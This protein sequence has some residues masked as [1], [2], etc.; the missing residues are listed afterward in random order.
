MAYEEDF[1]IPAEVAY[2]FAWMLF[3]A[4]LGIAHLYAVANN[5]FFVEGRG[6]TYPIAREYCAICPVVVDCLIEGL[7]SEVG[8]R[9]GCSPVERVEIRLALD[10]GGSLE[11]ETEAIWEEHRTNERGGKV[12]D[13]KV[14]RDWIT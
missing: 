9:G 2:D 12:P 10:Q 14:W 7:D 6:K 8:F 4:C 1:E 11:V 3:A 13:K 5:P